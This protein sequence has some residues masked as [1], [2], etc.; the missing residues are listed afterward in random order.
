M[1]GAAVIDRIKSLEFRGRSVRRTAVGGENELQI[2]TRIVFPDRYRQDISLPGGSLATILGPEGA[3]L[4]P[5]Q[6]GSI[7]L[8]EEQRLEIEM[9]IMRN[10]VALLKT[11]RDKTFMTLG[12]GSGESDGKRV[13]LLTVLSGGESTTL[14]LDMQT[15][16]IMRMRYTHRDAQAVEREMIEVIYSDFRPVDGLTY[17]FAAEGTVEGGVSFSNRLESLIIN[18]AVDLSLFVPP[19][20]SVEK[21]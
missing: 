5:S 1:G 2:T 20:P 16:R 4:V 17:P 7:P 18:G 6:G 10:P 3:F 8:P 15:G 13:E 12:A 11:R 9:A 14:S 21:R 19:P